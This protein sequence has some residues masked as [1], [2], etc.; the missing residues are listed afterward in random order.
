MAD[1]LAW[2]IKRDPTLITERISRSVAP[3][4][5]SNAAR[6]IQEY[7]TEIAHALFQSKFPVLFSEEQIRQAKVPKKGSREPQP[8]P[9][10]VLSF[11]TLECDDGLFPAS[12]ISC[13]EYKFLESS[14]ESI[15]RHYCGTEMH[16][17]EFFIDEGDTEK[18]IYAHFKVHCDIREFLT[19]YG[20]EVPDLREVL[21]IT[22]N[23]S[24]A[25]MTTVGLYMKQTWPLHSEVLTNMLQSML[26]ED[27]AEK[28]S[29]I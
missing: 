12:L 17:P 24:E 9:P 2:K 27:A 15:L 16:Q 11:E 1:R 29:K 22:G 25:Q 23:V 6:V 21:A 19:S 13:E 3:E 4:F 26:S 5:E 14:Y 18:D 8:Y 28:E 10:V 7:R 20:M